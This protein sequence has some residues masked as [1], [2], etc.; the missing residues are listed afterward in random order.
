MSRFEIGTDDFLLDGR[1]HRVLSG[2]LHYFRIHPGHWRDRIVAARD[3]GLNTIELYIAWNEHAPTRGE[4]TTDGAL[5]LGAFI[6]LVHE[7]GMHAIVR[8][9]PYICA[10]WDN[11]GLPAWLFTDPEVG[12]R[13]FE[14]RYMEAVEEYL[15][16]VYEIVRPRQIHNGGPV[17]LVQIENE[18]GAYGSDRDYL[19]RLVEVTRA[20]GIEVPLTTIDQPTHQMLEDGSLPELHK[21]GSFGSRSVER[22]ATLRQHQ[23]TGPLMCAEFWNGW[24]DH[25]GA[26]HHT[27][28][29]E[30]SAR[31]LD[32][33][34]ATGASVNLYMVHG[35]TNFGMTSGANDKGVYQPT[36]TSYDYDAPVDEAGRPTEKYLA[37]Q[38]VF[39]K[40]NG[41]SAEE[42]QAALDRATAAM[43]APA[44]RVAP[45]TSVVAAASRPLWSSFDF[46]GASETARPRTFDELGHYRG[47]LAT[48]AT[49]TGDDEQAVLTVGEVRDRVYV[50]LD[51]APV[52]VMAR[53]HHDVSVVLP[54]ATGEL[55]LL[56]EDQGRVN[57]GERIGEHKGVLGDVRVG[58]TVVT[59]WRTAPLDLDALFG[60]DSVLDE[61][62]A[63]AGSVA[64]PAVVTYDFDIE[65]AQDLFLDTSRW[66]K[67]VAAL[68]GFPLGR[69][70][71][72]GPQTT[73][74]VPGPAVHA[75]RN[76]LVVLEQESMADS[77]LRFAADLQLGH[78]DF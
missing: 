65:D 32:E 30:D 55:L 56:V 62:A 13:R 3:L 61:G 40:Y 9:G 46:D 71:R 37:F 33:L 51:G 19:R 22:L 72:R 2:S 70:W 15:E 59:G 39:A 41:R 47:F 63:I 76:R 20:A 21:T 57:Y 42:T 66:G 5:D 36:V 12:V 17:V 73:L 18:Y 43:G 26:H 4:W 38:R 44:S 28:S 52:G 27:T 11:G 68:N 24:F 1:P 7:E 34:L 74:F 6:D 10:E 77:A 16:R 50:F 45:T 54:R 64:G 14:P 31:D 75:G 53:D 78:T 49:L 69:Y 8:P 67:G 58:D 35:G 25:W 60:D 23:P 29:A 48:R